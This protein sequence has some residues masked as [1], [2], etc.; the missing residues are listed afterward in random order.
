M[1]NM[2]KTILFFGNE[3]LATGVNTNTPVL[4]AL[5]DNG[6]NVAAIVVAQDETGASRKNRTLEISELA[7]EQ[8]IPLLSFSSLKEA[9]QELLNYKAEAA[10]L[11]AYGKLI[12]SSIIEL[13][14]RGIIN[15]HPSLL[16]KHRGPTPLESTIL[17]GDPETGV[18]LMQLSLKMD[19]GAVFAQRSVSLQGNETKQ[20]LA[21]MLSDIGKEMLIEYLPAILEGTIKSHPQDDSMASYDQLIS[22]DAGTIKWDQPVELLDRQVRAYALWPRSRTKIGSVDVVITSSH[23]AQGS[24]EP[25]CVRRDGKQLGIHASDGVLIID[26]L[27]PSGKREMSS[28]AFLAGYRL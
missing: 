1:S 14:P 5:M 10:V 8:K 7:K 20:M 17:A 18:S 28:Q 22:K 25:G 21:D 16:P 19:A 6:Y 26:S 24:G 27:I 4:H 9:R 3:R 2:S 12:P 13:F 11:V 23:V 15:I